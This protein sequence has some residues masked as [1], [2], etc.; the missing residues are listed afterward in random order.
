MMGDHII[1]LAIA[2]SG[3]AIVSLI[4][5]YVYIKLGKEQTMTNYEKYKDKI[6]AIFNAN[7]EIAISKNTNEIRKC[8]TSD[9]RECLFSH[10][11]NN[12]IHCA[13]TTARWLLSEYV[14]PEVDWSKVSIDTPVLVSLDNKE[15]YRRYFA[16]V[17]E[18]NGN[19]KVF[20]NG[21]T[22]WSNEGEITIDIYFRYIKLAEVLDE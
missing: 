4:Y 13:I 1:H 14:E 17:D 22:R 12:N 8:R 10:R 20:T 2:Y 11:Y 19:P 15:W 9:C 5:L 3:S 18:E 7:C 6:D 16:G 21:A